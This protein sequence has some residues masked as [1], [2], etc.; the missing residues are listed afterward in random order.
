MKYTFPEGY[1]ENRVELQKGNTYDVTFE[2]IEGTF[3][4]EY[5]IKEIK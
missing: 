3:G 5:N 4:Y 1:S 2:V